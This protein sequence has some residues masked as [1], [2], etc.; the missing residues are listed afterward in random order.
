MG[1]LA[2]YENVI[3]VLQQFML[4]DSLTVDIAPLICLSVKWDLSEA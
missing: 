1:F 4:I 3:P 2:A